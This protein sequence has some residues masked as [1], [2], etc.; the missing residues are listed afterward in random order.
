MLSKDDLRPGDLLFGQGTGPLSRLIQKFDGSPYSHVGLY[1]GGD[2]IAQARECGL[3][4]SMDVDYFED[5]FDLVDVYRLLKPVS[6]IN[7]VLGRAEQY[8]S[9][10]GR[11]AGEE[12]AMIGILSV[13]K[14]AHRAL[15]HA[16]VR[17]L[18]RM[19]A[20]LEVLVD[21]V[22]H[23]RKGYP[24]I[25]SEFAYR[26]YVEPCRDSIKVD[27]VHHATLRFSSVMIEKR[28]ASVKPRPDACEH[29]QRIGADLGPEIMR[30]LEQVAT[31]PELAPWSPAPVSLVETRS[32]M[33]GTALPYSSENQPPPPLPDG[34]V[35]QYQ[36]P[37]PNFVSPGD[38][39]R[40]HSLN[41]IGRLGK[42]T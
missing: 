34:G 4:D 31:S 27:L 16:A 6:D 7:A 21:W 9:I 2:W 10:G 1:L 42:A 23:R 11:F 40:S 19:D 39:A 35:V 15:L 5:F 38:L 8:I 24:M 29:V 3:D 28:F 26:C 12:L 37:P 20:E 33:M 22:T 18:D 32:H 30:S 13:L 14:P 41:C 17:I 36:F 25:C